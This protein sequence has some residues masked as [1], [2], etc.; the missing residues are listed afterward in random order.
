MA[1]E[2]KNS[3]NLSPASW[4]TRK[5]RGI[6]HSEPKGL[7]TTSSHVQGQEKMDW[8]SA[9]AFWENQVPTSEHGDRYEKKVRSHYKD[10]LEL[11]NTL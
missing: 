6:T 3:H 8:T 5:A 9:S 7:R 4:G 2:A 1:M 11:E 10:I